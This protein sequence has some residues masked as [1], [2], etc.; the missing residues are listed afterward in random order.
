MAYNSF[1]YWYDR[2]NVDVDYDRLSREV[3]QRLGAHGV[4][5]GIVADLGCGTGELTLRLARAGYDMIAVDGSPDMLSVLREKAEDEDGGD[6]LLLCQNLESLDLFGT[7]RAAV[8]T[9]DTF[10]H[11][12]PADLQEAIRRTALFTEAQGMLIFDVNTPYKHKYVLGDKL[13]EASLEGSP[14]IYFEWE[15]SY[16]PEESSTLITVTMW[17]ADELMFTESF[18]EYSY[19]LEQ[20]ES[21]LKK[22]GYH[23]S[24]VVDGEKYTF[25]TDSSQ[26]LLITAIKE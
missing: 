23:I 20:L 13:F 14:D 19:S 7:I 10:N 3:Q 1:A 26:R 17:Q 5:Q 6:L 4:S 24:E 16:D 11:L 22:A 18:K 9:F 8:S 2:L 15:N 12:P 21:M 25:Q